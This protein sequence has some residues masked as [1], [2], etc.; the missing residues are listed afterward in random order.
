[1]PPVDTKPAEQSIPLSR[2]AEAVEGDIV[3]PLMAEGELAALP[4]KNELT[5][6]SPPKRTKVTSIK[7]KGSGILLNL[8]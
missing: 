1:M 7:E 5:P 6:S 8:I 4:R 3:G 2:R